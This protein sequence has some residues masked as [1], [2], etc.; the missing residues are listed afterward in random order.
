VS[1]RSTSTESGFVAGGEALIFGMLIFVLGTIVVLNAW[2]V[3]D[4]RFAASAAAREAVRAVVE[5]PIGADL[6][7]AAIAAA[8]MAFEGHGRDPA[9]LE[10]I[11]AG[12]TEDPVQARCAEIRFRVETQVDV[13]VVPRFGTRSAFR[14]SAVHAELIE[15]YRSG[16]EG[17][18]CS[19]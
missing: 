18:V 2:T 1:R 17:S 6:D 3:L 7:Q 12:A 15:P 5:A 8:G 19:P 11:W 10:V 9:D 14:V 16:L 13:L 4:A